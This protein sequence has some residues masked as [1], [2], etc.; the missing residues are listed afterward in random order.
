MALRRYT[1]E[2]NISA[3]ELV[4]EQGCSSVRA[5][6]VPSRLPK[7]AQATAKAMLHEIWQAETK[8]AAETAFHLFLTMFEAKYPKVTV[9]LARD[10]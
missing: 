5:A 1:R 3:V 9:C 2:F 10:R 7:S 6:K 8:A 4:N